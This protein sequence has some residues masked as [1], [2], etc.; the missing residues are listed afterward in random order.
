MRKYLVIGALTA[1]LALLIGTT[2][3]VA[4]AAAQL[5]GS[6]IKNNSIKNKKLKKETIKAN[7]IK[8]GTLTSA[9]VGDGSLTALDLNATAWPFGSAS[10]VAPVVTSA[11]APTQIASA[12]VTMAKAGVLQATFAAQTAC[13]NTAAFSTSCSVDVR[14]DNVLMQGQDTENTFDSND[15]GAETSQSVEANSVTRTASV[16]AGTHTVTVA[17]RIQAS[18]GGTPNFRLDNWNLVAEGHY[19]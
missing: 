6:Q 18:G 7:K 12:Q 5:N 16:A 19:L 2:P 13:W 15:P 3:I 8:P 4:D 17:F 1:V 9:Q 14:V 10:G 11:T